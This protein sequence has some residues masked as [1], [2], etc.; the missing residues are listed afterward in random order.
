MFSAGVKFFL[1]YRA[2]EHGD[3]AKTF[4][5]RCDGHQNTLVLVET[6]RE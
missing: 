5:E 6:T 1:I 3:R 2:S 4:H